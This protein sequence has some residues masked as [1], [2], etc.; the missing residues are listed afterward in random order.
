[1]QVSVLYYHFFP[2]YHMKGVVKIA[3][4]RCHP[5]TLFLSFHRSVERLHYD[6]DEGFSFKDIKEEIEMEESDDDDDLVQL[7]SLRINTSQL[8]SIAS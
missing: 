2:D 6:D 8:K 1:M 5:L 3:G 4:I 7:D